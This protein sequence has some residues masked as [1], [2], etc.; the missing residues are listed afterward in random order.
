MQYGHFD[1]ENKE[2]VITRP[3]TPL[4]WINY[5]GTREYCALISNT[6]GGYSFYKDA[7]QR[8]LTRYRYNNIPLD[9]NGRYV[10]LL[11]EES[12]DFWSASWQPVRKDASQQKYECRHGLSYTVISS[13]YAGIASRATYLVPEGETLEA[14]RVELTNTTKRTRKL[15]AVS[16][17]EF[18]L[19]DALNDQTD[20]Q[21][22]LNIG[23]AKVDRASSTIYHLSRYRVSQD[24]YAFF[25]VN[26]PLASF[27]TER[28]E[29]LG[30]YGSLQAPAHVKTGKG[31]NTL[32]TDWAPSGSHFTRLSLKP[33]ESTTLIYVLGF[34]FKLGDREE[35]IRR[36]KR[37]SVFEAALATLK[38][39]W[40]A[41]LSRYQCQTP[42]EDVNLMVNIWN[43]YQCRTTFNW[44]RSASYFE[45]GIGRGM[46]F[47]DS[48]QD[49]MGFVHQIP[50]EVRQ[51]I[52]D[53]ATTQFADGSARHQYSPLTKK[54]NGSGFSDD[55]LW[56]V[57]STTAYVHETGDLKML[58]EMVGF[59]DGSRATLY[60]HL[61]RAT[62]YTWKNTGPHGL[63]KI[64]RADW[65][66]CMNLDQGKVEK[67]LMAESRAESVM[68]AQMFVKA[69]SDLA[70]LA[71]LLGKAS[72]AR[73][74]T[75]QGR[76]MAGRIERAAWDGGWY[77]RAFTE[78]GRSVGSRKVKQGSI[79]HLN[80]Q[81]WAVL[82]GAAPKQR[83][84]QAMD[85]VHKLL[86]TKYGILLN[87]PAY[88]EFDPKLGFISVFPPGLK[89]NG[90]IFCHP[91]PWAVIAETM[92]GRGDRAMAYYKAILPAAK[93][94]IAD[95]HRTEPYVYSQMIAGK[96]SPK[97][98]QAKN[99]WLTG[100]ASWNFIAVSQ[101]ILGVRAEFNGL[102]V[103]PCVPRTWKDFSITRKFRGGTYHIHVRN[104][105]GVQKGVK[106][107]TVDGTRMKDNLAPV[108][109]A[110]EHRVEVVMG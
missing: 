37:P 29:F 59:D 36:Y 71:T 106:S 93:N 76:E 99:S 4:P 44:S 72:Q 50:G 23:Q 97:F 65:N 70:G 26:R 30:P 89:E 73:G 54:G 31:S 85:A 49:T 80:S 46:G 55:H 10:Y 109:T 14:W 39:N 9:S 8:R 52:L 56:L 38:S 27:D 66:D 43:Q 5:L 33:G 62:A 87:W 90:A 91:N 20:F 24:H 68:V 58:E 25:S 82:S 32:A 11:D 103:D 19:W 69:C 53:L 92:L 42:D 110:S 17:V 105:L 74:W 12:R 75:G 41:N 95:T 84:R 16:F 78:E 83:G 7:S 45:A 47:R 6:A 86:A 15:T 101:Y 108:F 2:Y 67:G 61:A 63:P 40:E 28:S 100:T 1:R 13:Q 81:S 57:L 104:P 51:R 21:Y 77:T 60:E 22:N 48:N 96:E 35:Q 64:L 107:M 102:R 79:I 3:D 94:A 18:C 98:G 34:G 88:R